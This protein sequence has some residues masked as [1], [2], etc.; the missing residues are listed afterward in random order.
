MSSVGFYTVKITSIF[1][2]SILYFL[3]GSVLSILLNEM[4][5]SESLEEIQTWK[6]VSLMGLIFGSI[7][8]VFYVVRIMIKRMPFFLDGYYGFKYSILREAAG[9][10]IIGYTMY[11]FLNKLKGLMD[12]LAKRMLYEKTELLRSTVRI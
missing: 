6:L 5:P 8:V 12:E 3:V 4:I 7:G 2:I 9:G 1:L 11:A 10:I